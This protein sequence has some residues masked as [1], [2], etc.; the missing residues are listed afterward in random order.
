MSSFP[1]V[2]LVHSLMLLKY[3]TSFSF[4]HLVFYLLAIF[5][6]SGSDAFLLLFYLLTWLQSLLYIIF[7][8]YYHYHCFQV[9]NRVSDFAGDFSDSRVIELWEQAKKKGFSK[10]ELESIKV[11]LLS[12]I[13]YHPSFLNSI[14]YF[15]LKTTS[16]TR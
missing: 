6:S 5:K 7:F 9:K 14:L 11:L 4:C 15:S 13:L 1:F 3:S 16:L 8:N 10:L 12:Y 2:L